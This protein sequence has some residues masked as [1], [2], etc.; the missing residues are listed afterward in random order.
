MQTLMLAL[1][2]RVIRLTSK[3]IAAEDCIT[4]IKPQTAIWILFKLGLSLKNQRI[5]VGGCKYETKQDD[6]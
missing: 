1:F 4:S 3:N 6:R 2:F 5:Q